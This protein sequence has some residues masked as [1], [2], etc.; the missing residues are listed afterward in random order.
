[1]GV[2]AGTRGLQKAGPK[3]TVLRGLKKKPAGFLRPAR[4]EDAAG[5]GLLPRGI[6]RIRFRLSRDRVAL[7]VA[8]DERAGCI[9][10]GAVG[11]VVDHQLALVVV[12]GPMAG[13][14]RLVRATRFPMAG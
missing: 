9:G 3:D 10:G 2:A 14:P 4:D 11:V 12:P 13:D 7:A 6:D 8:Q 5:G 1:M